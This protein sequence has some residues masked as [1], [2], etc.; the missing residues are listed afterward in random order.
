AAGAAPRLAALLALALSKPRAPGPAPDEAERDEAEVVQLRI[1]AKHRVVEGLA[2]GGPLLHA[3]ALFRE[4]DR[5]PPPTRQPACLAPDA[6]LRLP[7]PSEGDW[8]C[9]VV[10]TFA[11]NS[12]RTDRPD[13]AEA[14]TRRLVGEFWAAGGGRGAVRVPD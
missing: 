3:A 11:R 9:P 14:A 1:H 10:I 4:L 12:L 8:H 7:S 5:L 13:R 6:P 2:A